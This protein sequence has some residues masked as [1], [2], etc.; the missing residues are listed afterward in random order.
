MKL[1]QIGAGPEM[2]PFIGF[3]GTDTV[4]NYVT[5]AY[6]KYQEKKELLK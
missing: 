2:A 3:V 1:I 5:K 4:M 6:A